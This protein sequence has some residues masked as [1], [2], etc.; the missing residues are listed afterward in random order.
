MLLGEELV[1]DQLPELERR[2]GRR[3]A[4]HNKHR[5]F[6]RVGSE[7][8]AGVAARAERR[9]SGRGTSHWF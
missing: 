7:L 2:A 4:D 9:P 6:E 3:D 8:L 5:P 1:A